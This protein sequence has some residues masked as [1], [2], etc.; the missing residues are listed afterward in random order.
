[1]SEPDV[2][3]KKHFDQIEVFGSM[4]K[5]SW[6]HGPK[7]AKRFFINK[8]KCPVRNPFDNIHGVMRGE[9]IKLFENLVWQS[10][11]E[12]RNMPKPAKKWFDAR[13][14]DFKAGEDIDLVCNCRKFRGQDNDVG[15]LAEYPS[16]CHGYTLKKYIEF[17]AN[18]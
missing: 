6:V 15:L 13:V 11:H 17:L 12:D 9:G 5:R 16:D 2:H 4:E 1:M 7:S 18:Q 10:W 8:P 14:K 3:K